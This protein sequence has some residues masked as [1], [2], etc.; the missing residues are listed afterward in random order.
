MLSHRVLLTANKLHTLALLFLPSASP[1]LLVSLHASD[2]R[3]TVKCFRYVDKTELWSTELPANPGA[4]ARLPS[5]PSRLLVHPSTPLSVFFAAADASVFL[6]N[7][8]DGT[9]I[10]HLRPPASSVQIG[11][12][13]QASLCLRSLSAQAGTD[14]LCAAASHPD[15]RL[16][17]RCVDLSGRLRAEQSIAAV[18]NYTG[19]RGTAAVALPDGRGGDVPTAWLVGGA[20]GSLCVPQARQWRAHQD[21]IGQMALLNDSSG[22]CPPRVLSFAAGDRSLKLWDLAT[23]AGASKE[24][25]PGTT[26]PLAPRLA[27]PPELLNGQRPLLTSGFSPDKSKLYLVAESGL[28]R[29]NVSDGRLLG[30][31]RLAS[32]KALEWR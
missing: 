16:L 10:S 23:I 22:L 15:G 9:L 21:R 20:L 4:A 6:L 11:G 17:L 3:Y 26:Q 19:E 14:W 27:P 18:D 30:T 31:V 32:Q 28:S 5:D 1:R 25:S 12:T 8:V 24:P 7:A 13:A 29:W 2:R